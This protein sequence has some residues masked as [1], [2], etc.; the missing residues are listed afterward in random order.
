VLSKVKS[1][2]KVIATSGSIGKKGFPTFDGMVV[3]A[4]GRPRT[5]PSWSRW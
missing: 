3:N 4:P 2:G 5:R 1:N